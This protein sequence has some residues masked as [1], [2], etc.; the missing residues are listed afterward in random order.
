MTDWTFFKGFRGH[1]QKQVNLKAV[2]MTK[3]DKQSLSLKKIGHY[4]RLDPVRLEEAL[5]LQAQ[6]RAKGQR[7]RLGELQLREGAV[8][9]QELARALSLQRL[10]RLA[11][12]L[13]FA[14][15]NPEEL[16]NITPL[17][18]E[19][20]REEGE[21][22]IGQ[23]T[24]GDC[25]YILANG[26]AEVC[27]AGDYGEIV[28]L[29]FI[30]P[31]ESI[32][33]MGYFSDGR[34]TASVYAR[35]RCDLIRIGYADIQDILQNSPP[36]A[37]NFLDMITG[38]LRRTNIRFQEI[39]EHSRKV[40][41]NLESLSRFLDMS[42]YAALTS[43]I[44]G[45]IERIVF[46]A[47]KVMDAERASLFLVD[48]AAGELWSKVAEGLR[49]K[50][51]RVPIGQGVAGWV[52]L[53]GETVN[54]PD[55]YADGRFDQ[56]VDRKTGF[57]T[58]N[59]LCGPIKNLQG[60]LVGVIEV[61]NKADGD[62]GPRE[63][64]LFKAFAYQ[65]A[66]ALENFYLYSRL[67]NSHHQMAILLDVTIALSQT[68]DLDA[69][70]IKI[71]NKMREILEAERGTLF[72]WDRDTDELWSK[73]VLGDGMKEIRLPSAVGLVGHVAR[74]G[75]M[76]HIENAYQDPRF[77][78]AVD[79]ETGFLT[80]NVLC[81]PV[82][83]R[84]GQVIGVTE[85]I[86]KKKGAFASSDIDMLKGLN[87]Q[88]AVALENA[89][90]YRRTLQMKN[91]LTSVQN[92]ISNAI[93]TID[94]AGRV[95]MANQAAVKLFSLDRENFGKIDFFNLLHSDNA[96]LLYLLHRVRERR[97]A[98]VDYDLVINLADGNRHT[99]NVNFLPLV[100]PAEERQ[101]LVLIFENITME[102]RLRS[103]LTR[104]MAK[105]IVERILSDEHHQTL[106]G[107]K[108][109]ATIMFTDIREFTSIA[110]NFSPEK[111]IEFLNQYFSVMVDLIFINEGVLDKYI[112]DNIMAVFGVPFAQDND[113]I[114]AVRTS[115]QMRSALDGMNARR[116][117]AGLKPIEI[118]IGICTGEVVSGNIGTDKRMEYT[119][120]GD[121]VNIASRLESLCGY[122][123]VDILIG[124][125]TL[126][127][128]NGQ[129]TTRSIDYVLVKGK[130]KPVH[131]YEVLCEGKRSLTAAE[132]RFAVGLG[133]YRQRSFER[134]AREFSTGGSEDRLCKIFFDRCRDF[135]K[136]PP[137]EDWNGVWS[138]DDK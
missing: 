13:L 78:P 39:A 31:G 63:E 127:E 50:E 101:G 107:I 37:R 83:N 87:S 125:T 47:S 11:S 58:R 133:F 51:I 84:Q 32:G 69:L 93:V 79:R 100:Y 46:T 1:G 54:I 36:L 59:I 80:R 116:T 112:G 14:G 98:M 102:K 44:D 35:E 111:T 48:A 57:R 89:Q 66:V 106:G 110:E 45:L 138:M 135:L 71:V 55:A 85:T 76:L 132:E 72:L 73:V 90:L 123:G 22:I 60:E 91:Y 34:R 68:L 6:L 2:V 42:D 104:Y 17:V 56:S 64:S 134:A 119:V 52:A 128:L 28:S 18:R 8:T 109:K 70:I 33:E 9:S 19:I 129:F 77:N 92:S 96:R 24:Q 75:E 4:L 16:T 136:A 105:D 61:I 94:D 25:F 86:N 21:E 113:A 121:E 108:S 23:D 82:V 10:D 30:E 103:T 41:M 3:D 131:I 53:H 7:I 122:Y 43:G 27:R 29:A 118:G 38:R 126:R 15:I 120:I 97:Q 20:S 65:T 130:K 26:R 81:L 88:I 12:C 124:E 74:T 5:T 115:L 95:M 49:Q 99:V 62:Y 67:L 137:P 117:A 114:R 40:E